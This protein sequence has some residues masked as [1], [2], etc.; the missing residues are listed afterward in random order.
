[1]SYGCVNERENK[2]AFPFKRKRKF[3]AVARKCFLGIAEA[4]IICDRM[5]QDARMRRLPV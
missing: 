5:K 2:Q 1:M 3:R 4:A